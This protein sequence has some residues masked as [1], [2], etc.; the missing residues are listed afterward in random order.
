MESFFWQGRPGMYVHVK[1]PETRTEA[2]RISQNMERK[3]S[4]NPS[5]PHS[6]IYHM[7]KTN[8]LHP[9]QIPPPPIF[10]SSPGQQRSAHEHACILHNTYRP[11][12]KLKTGTILAY[13]ER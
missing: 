9:L 12:V 8:Y 3:K 1:A 5:A 11:P 10:N 2:E 6:P 13:R 7:Y 4:E